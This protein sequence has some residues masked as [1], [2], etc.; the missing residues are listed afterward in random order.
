VVAKACLFHRILLLMYSS[1]YSLF[2]SVLIY[3]GDYLLAKRLLTMQRAK[4]EN[5]IRWGTQEVRNCE[6]VGP[7]TLNP[8]KEQQQQR[9]QAA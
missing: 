8:V 3:W 6:P 7:T 1:S 4:D 9:L 5:P 2:V